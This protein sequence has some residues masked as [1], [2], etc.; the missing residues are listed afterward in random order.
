VKL[1][2]SHFRIFG[3]P[4]YIHFPKDKRTNLDPFGKKGTFFGYIK[5]SKAYKIYIPGQIQIEV[6]WDVTFDEDTTF[7]RSKESHMEIDNEEKEALKDVGS[8]PSVLVDHPSYF[9]E[10][11]GDLVE[12][13]HLPRF[14]VP[15]TRKRPV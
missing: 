12:P 3:F 13:V 9:R 6:N 5:K 2:V 10:K 11:S 8:S 15:E 1:E 14:V 4:V 7:G